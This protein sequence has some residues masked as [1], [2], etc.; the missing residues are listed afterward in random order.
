MC[1]EMV[2]DLACA[3]TVHHLFD[4]GVSPPTP[5]CGPHTP[6][7]LIDPFGTPRVLYKC[8]CVRVCEGV[9]LV[10]RWPAL[11]FAGRAAFVLWRALCSFGLRSER[12]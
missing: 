6:R 10:S 8:A 7:L 12:H 11:S 5:C 9:C 1:V 2:T 4:P 3:E